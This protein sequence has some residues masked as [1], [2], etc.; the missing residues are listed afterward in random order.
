MTC[1]LCFQPT[2][3]SI[4]TCLTRI[5]IFT[6]CMALSLTKALSGSIMCFA[7]ACH[8]WL[9]VSSVSGSDRKVSIVDGLVLMGEWGGWSQEFQC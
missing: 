3:Y 5:E 7:A 4:N 6:A 9:S 2:W 1:L 8:R